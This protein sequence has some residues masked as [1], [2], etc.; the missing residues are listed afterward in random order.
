MLNCM[1]CYYSRS[2]LV[3]DGIC[4]FS[5]LCPSSALGVLGFTAQLMAVLKTRSSVLPPVSAEG[6]LGSIQS[7]RAQALS[8][9]QHMSLRETIPQCFSH[10]AQY[11]E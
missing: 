3:W 9:Q 2:S 8:A 5:S 6:C 7:Q 1:R 4:L 11:I 10:K